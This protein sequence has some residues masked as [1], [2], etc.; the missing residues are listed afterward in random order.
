[1]LLALACYSY[2]VCIAKALVAEKLQVL[3]VT[4][5]Q[6]SNISILKHEDII[7]AAQQQQQQEMRQA[8][9]K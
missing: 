2:W 9:E 8:K 5:C 3:L 6:K 4:E 1:M 7:Q